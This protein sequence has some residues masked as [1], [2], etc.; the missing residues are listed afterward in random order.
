M[1]FKVLSLL[2]AAGLGLGGLTA[3]SSPSPEEKVSQAVQIIKKD[4]HKVDEVPDPGNR[5][6]LT[7]NAGWE[8][9]TEKQKKRKVNGKTVTV[10]KNTRVIEVVIVI[11]SSNC[12]V[13]VEAL[14]DGDLE[15]YYADEGRDQNG[16][17]IELPQDFPADSPSPKDLKDYLAKHKDRFSFCV[18]KP[19]K[20][21]T[22][23]ND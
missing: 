19:Y 20:A 9:E 14:M 23:A 6:K 13:E 3:C 15:A 16:K 7:S 21:S 10:K 17:E 18:D 22:H 5:N 12:K 1:R 2:V 11:P 8:T 4:G